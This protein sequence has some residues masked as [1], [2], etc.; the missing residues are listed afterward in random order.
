MKAA[1][2]V[3]YGPPEVVRVVDIDRPEIREGRVLIKVHGASVNPYDIWHRKGYLPVRPSAGL[4]K[5]NTHILGIDVAGTVEEVGEGVTEFSVGDRVF[6]GCLGSHA[7][8]VRAFPRNLSKIPEKITFEHA[9]V[10]Q[11]AGVTA[12]QALRDVGKIEAGQKVLVYGASG[13]IGHLAVQLAVHFGA[14][15][16]AVCSTGNQEWVKALGAHHVLDYTREDFARRGE[17]YDIILDAV[18]K[19]TFFNS[20]PVLKS[21]GVYI[22]EHVLFPRYHPIQFMIASLTGDRRAKTHLARTNAADLAFMAGL[23]AEDKLKPV[24]EKAFSLDEI[25]AAHR[26]LEDGHTKGKISVTP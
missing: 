21:T 16:T 8:Y 9:G 5:P 25:A 14:E 11:A 22:T 18:G 17:Q 15:V 7:E 13:G 10:M 6:G 19:R 3:S 26:H 1:V 12:V 20:R 4:V 24:I 23:M 2:N